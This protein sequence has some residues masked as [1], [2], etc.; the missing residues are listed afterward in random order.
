[1]LCSGII[2]ADA[3]I[4]QKQSS[5]HPYSETT[6]DNWRTIPLSLTALRCT[7]GVSADRAVVL[8]QT[9][10]SRNLHDSG[11]RDYQEIVIELRQSLATTNVTVMW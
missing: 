1:M 7:T 4:N 6:G 3:S 11:D 8:F 9:D 10:N 2:A 5:I